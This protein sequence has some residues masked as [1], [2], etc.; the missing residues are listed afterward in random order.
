MPHVGVCII[1]LTGFKYNTITSV[2]YS[3][4]V[5]VVVLSSLASNSIVFGPSEHQHWVVKKHWLLT[6][7]LPLMLVS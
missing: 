5:T 1:T 6:S 2:M 7:K 3:K 4:E